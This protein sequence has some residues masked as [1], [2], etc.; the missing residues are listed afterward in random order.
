[1]LL[2]YVKGRTSQESLT[3]SRPAVRLLKQW[4]EHS[5]VARRFAPPELQEHLWLRYWSGGGSG[6]SAGRFE[7]DARAAW[8]R[9]WSTAGSVDHEDAK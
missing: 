9:T 7:T 3:L 1:M 5:A 6:W 4:L 2:D 8:V